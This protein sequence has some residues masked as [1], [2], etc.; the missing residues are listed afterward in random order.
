MSPFSEGE[1]MPLG[2]KD[3]KPCFFGTSRQTADT[4]GTSQKYRDTIKT[5]YDLG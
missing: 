2:K 1:K 3:F 4:F 5:F